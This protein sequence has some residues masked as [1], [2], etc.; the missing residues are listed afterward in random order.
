VDGDK[1]EKRERGGG[2]LS[3]VVEG[4]VLDMLRDE[5]G[6]VMVGWIQFFVSY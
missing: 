3:C 1:A 2:G 4:K 6:C 5:I